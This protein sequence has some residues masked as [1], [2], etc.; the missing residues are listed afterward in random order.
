VAVNAAPF[1]VAFADKT[2]RDACPP[3]DFAEGFGEW[4]N[5]LSPV[6][7]R[8]RRPRCQVQADL[9]NNLQAPDDPNM[10]LPQCCVEG[11]R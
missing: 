4:T 10:S 2:L 6:M 1:L 3:H 5:V 8:Q 7:E 9:T 11:C